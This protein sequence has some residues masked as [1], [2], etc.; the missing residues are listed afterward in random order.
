MNARTK[1][2]TFL[3]PI[4]VWRVAVICTVLCAGLYAGAQ[5][6][7]QSFSA[8]KVVTRRGQT[9]TAKVYATPAAFRTEGVQNGK[10]FIAIERFDRKVIW[11]LMPDQMLYVEVAMPDGAQAAAALMDL[12]KGVQAKNESL[13]SE[14]MDGFLCDKSRTTVT[15]GGITGSS[16]EWAAKELGGFVVKKQ[17]DTS[18]EITE[19]KNI[20]LGPQD[21]SLFE[22][23]AAYRKMS[24]SGGQ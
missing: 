15:W 1:Q 5:L 12:T 19:Y 3:S 21:P 22:L 8:D 4:L 23:P 14:Q 10:K 13:G 24:L 17:D 9:T 7:T 11:S 16:T 2:S 18:G 20:Q 6:T